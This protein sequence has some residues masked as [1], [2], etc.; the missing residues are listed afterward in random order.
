MANVEYFKQFQS[1]LPFMEGREK[2]ALHMLYGRE[3]HIV[4]YGF[5]KNDEGE[6]SCFVVA[7]EPGFFY[8]GNSIITK[9]LEQVDKDGMREDLAVMRIVFK[10]QKSA[11]GRDYT[12]FE[13]V[14]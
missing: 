7:E 8:F 6:Y 2:A 10:Q 3:V 13:F 14:F 9:M 1:G 12:A 4:D 11:K 5:M